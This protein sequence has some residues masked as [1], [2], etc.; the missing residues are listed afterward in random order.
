MATKGKKNPPRLSKAEAIRRAVN[1]N[2][3]SPPR[4][5]AKQLTAQGY[6]MTAAYVS[7]IKTMSKKRDKTMAIH[8]GSVS[9][10]ALKDAKIFV[11]KAGGI[12]EAK[13]LLDVLEH[14]Q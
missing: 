9:I 7:A 3:D 11:E 2:P 6:E 12:E 14:L 1:A 13:R 5:L 4:V 8:A 10:E